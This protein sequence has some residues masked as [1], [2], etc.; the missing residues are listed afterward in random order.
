MLIQYNRHG[1]TL[2]IEIG[3]TRNKNTLRIKK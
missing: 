3:A 1:N 2:D